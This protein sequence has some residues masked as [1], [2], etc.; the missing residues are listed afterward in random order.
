M[1]EERLPPHNLEAEE[2][3]LGS[4]LLDPTCV[5]QIADFLRVGDF[6]RERNNWVYEA[7]LALY[8]RHD[9]IDVVTLCDELERQGRLADL[10]GAAY[11]T[12]LMNAVPTAAHV[13][14]Y[15]RIVERAATLRRLIQAGSEIVRLAYQEG[16]DVTQALDKAEQLVFGV[17]ERRTGRDFIALRDALRDYFDQLDTLHAH[18]GQLIG[19]PTGFH[20]LDQVLGGLHRSDL[21]I[22][23]GRPSAG[24]T[25]FATGIAQ[26]LA[27]SARK[28]VALFSLEM[29][30]E[31]L[32]QRLLCSE[33]NVDSQRLRAGYIDDEEWQR[34]TEAMGTLSEA[35][36]YIDDSANISVMELRTKAR[37]L[38]AQFDIAAVFIDYLQLM[39][40]NGREN[41]VQ[42]VSEISR[43]LKGLARELDVPVVALSQLSRAVETR[44]PPTPILSDL[45]ESGSI[46]QDADVVMFVHREEMYNQNTERKN[47]ADIIIAKHRNGPIGR[48]P[49]RWF[50]SQTRFADLATAPAEGGF[51]DDME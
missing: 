42:E 47:I 49:L 51:E 18:K 22:V 38:K 31:Q 39:Q 13:E 7:D 26:H 30:S 23:A 33:A 28:A 6:Y 15:A 2:A 34:V 20:D 19:L 4:L 35:P 3:V 16:A 11:I 48:V 29:S 27:V 40:G 46:E 21:V 24:K 10:G 32:V 1:T 37:R 17:A 36:V 25:S 12:S 5:V 44:S 41:R 8:D 43:S 50:P 45:R 9:M 14:H